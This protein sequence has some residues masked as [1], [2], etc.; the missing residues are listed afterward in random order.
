MSQQAGRFINKGQRSF[1]CALHIPHE[2]GW[3]ALSTQRTHK[4]YEL[5]TEEV[6]ALSSDTTHNL[7]PLFMSKKDK[8][9]YAVTH[10]SEYEF[11]F[12]TTCPLINKGQAQRGE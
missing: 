7:C 10:M 3:R 1:R 2:M 8:F 4:E 11:E 12:E 6:N 9:S 5:K